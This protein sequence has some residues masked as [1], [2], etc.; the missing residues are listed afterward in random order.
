MGL[1]QFEALCIGLQEQ[2]LLCLS[3]VQS[4]RHHLLATVKFYRLKMM[5]VDFDFVDFL[6]NY[7][8]RK[9]ELVLRPSHQWLGRKHF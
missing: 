2:T 1:L 9:A 7:E 8:A 3:C 6:H 5:L 4:T